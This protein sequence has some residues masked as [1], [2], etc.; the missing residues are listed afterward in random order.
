MSIIEYPPG[1]DFPGK[2]G[3]TLDESSPAWPAP[4]RAPEGAPNVLVW[5]IDDVGFGQMSPYGGLVETPTL[6][7]LADNGLRYLNMHTTAL[8]SPTRGCILTGRNHHTL[9]L[10]AITELSVGYPAHNGYMAFEHGFVSEM[11]LEQG[12]NTFAIGKWHLTPP[13]EGTLSGPF[14]RWPL[15]RGF[16]R[17]YG[18]LGGDTD[19]WHPDLT[20]DNHPI[21]PPTTPEEGYHLNIDMTDKAIEFIKDAN[22]S[23]PDK[24]FYLYF[25]TGAGHAPHH[26]EPEWIEKYR[27]RFDEGWEV[28]RDTVLAN[29]IEMGIVPP[30]TEMSRLDPDV[31]EWDSLSDDEQRLFI[32]QMET[33][34]GFVSQTDY[35]FGRIVDYLEV[36]GELDNT[37]I[38]VI[39]DNGPSAEGGANG[40]Y[41]EMLFFN[42]APEELEDNLRAYD[43]W[44]N[45]NT[46]PHYSW[47]W[48]HAG[49]TPFRRWKRETYRGGISDPCIVSWPAKITGGGELRAQYCHAI[50]IVPTILEAVGV[51]PP[52]SVRG[53]PQSE[54]QGVS[55]APTFNDGSAP[56]K[57]TTQYFEMFGHRSLY[58]DGWRAVCPFPGTSFTEALEKNR[59][60]GSPLDAEVLADL[61]ANS[62]ELYNLADDPAENHNLAESNPTK[63]KEMIDLW[64]VEADRFGVLPLATGDLA[65][66]NVERPSTARPRQKFVYQAGGNALP[67]AASPRVYNRPHSITADVV[68]PESGGDGVLLCHGNRHGGYSLFMQDGY[69]NHVHNYLGRDAFKVT[70]PTRVPAGEASLRYEFEPT[71]E[72]ANIKGKGTSGRSQLYINGELVAS[73]DL[74]YTVPNLFGIIGLCCGRDA[75]D[76]VVPED[77]VAPFEF[78]GEIKSVTL[79]VTGDVI[80]DDEAEHKRIMAQQ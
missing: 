48:T 45:P 67:F 22:N 12:Y 8:C 14:H 24:P 75:T 68:I 40:T 53:V 27:G 9:G 25:A 78:N 18:F 59:Y 2:I 35:H 66:M 38:I 16:E 55:F 76:S 65:R 33:F 19:Q 17:Y 70:S 49:A 7:R 20:Y 10:S 3:K 30:N 50:D 6:D 44:G 57:R 21:E 42:G 60:F 4:T 23:A 13:E 64:Y 74:P 5:V 63:L 69:L 52:A 39:S 46:F 51:E 28:Y 43:D 32:R 26:V 41:N 80:V 56:S 77:Y 31:P 29:Q 34:A 61:D 36:I 73:V 62:W 1:T 15:G 47:G 71:G 72:L 37:L 11:L 58:N 79:D 54:I